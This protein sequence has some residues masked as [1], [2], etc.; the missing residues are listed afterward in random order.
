MKTASDFMIGASRRLVRFWDSCILNVPERSEDPYATHIPVLLFSPTLRPIRHV[1]E[2]GC[3]RYSTMLFLN[4]SCFPDLETLDSYEDE[5]RWA[6]A[7]V[8]DADSDCR[9]R[10]HVTPGAVA[11]AAKAVCCDDYDLV[12]IDDSTSVGARVKTISAVSAQRPARPLVLVHDFEMPE[13]RQ[14]AAGFKNRFRFTALNPNTGLVWNSN[15]IERSRLARFN[16]QLRN[17]RGTFAENDVRAYLRF[18][19][20]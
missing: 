16:R 19:Q 17:L 18:L 8:A 10:M 3:G 2:F 7:I 5:P 20:S 14:A 9:L 11:E 4:R 12:F 6:E 1:V 13:Y 15:Q